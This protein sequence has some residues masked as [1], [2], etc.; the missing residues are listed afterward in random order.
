MH[1]VVFT[2][3]YLPQTDFLKKSCFA[4]VFSH[5]VFMVVIN[6][7]KHFC[8]EL[9]T[10]IEKLI[11]ILSNLNKLTYVVPMLEFHPPLSDV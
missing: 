1:S 10:A 2:S 7:L 3:R 8:K 6:A 9:H 4:I 11:L 5:T